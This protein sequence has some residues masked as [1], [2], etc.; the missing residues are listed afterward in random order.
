METLDRKTII[1]AL[2]DLNDRLRELGIV[3]DLCLYGGGTMVVA[4]NARLST[5]D[6][7]AVFQPAAIIRK[8]AAA[9]AEERGLKADWLNDGVK[10]WL[11]SKER[12]VPE[13]LPQFSHLRLTRPTERYLLAMKCLAARAAGFE[14]QG[15]RKDIV[16]LVRALGLRTADEVLKIVEDFYPEDRIQPKTR[17]LVEEIMNEVAQEGLSPE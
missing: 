15:D 7:D 5:Q 13:N 6:V 8:A 4:F 1:A 14:T 2:A 9:I 16:F 10:G 12:L 11:S 3:G 17:F